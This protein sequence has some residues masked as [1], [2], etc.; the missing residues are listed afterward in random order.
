MAAR[1]TV[2]EVLDQIFQDEEAD[3]DL[4]E[5]VSE[6][7]DNMEEN[8]DYSPSDEDDSEGEVQAARETF[9]SKNN[10]ISWSSLPHQVAGRMAAENVIQMTPGPTRHFV[11]IP[12]LPPA[13]N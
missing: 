11:N 3:S 4:E 6:Q 5:D 1:L 13:S 8:S 10:A 2:Q 12:A 7:E 9:M